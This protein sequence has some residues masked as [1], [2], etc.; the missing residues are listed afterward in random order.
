MKHPENLRRAGRLITALL[1]ALLWPVFWTGAATAQKGELKELE[2]ALQ[3]DEA[4][5]KA[6]AAELEALRREIKTLRSK[7]TTAARTAQDLEERLTRGEDRLKD[8]ETQRAAKLKVLE[9]QHSRLATTLAAL[10]RIARRPPEAVIV[11]PGSP[12][13]TY[14]SALLLSRAIPEIEGQA[15]ALRAELLALDGLRREIA[16]EQ[17]DLAEASQALSEERLS[18]SELIVQKRRLEDVT[19]AER[20]AARARVK[21]WAR[22]A[23]GLRE[24]LARLEN[25]AEAGRR[26]E[27][28]RIR[29][30]LAA[31]DARKQREAAKAAEAERQQQAQADQTEA[32]AEALTE[33]QAQTET[34]T[35]AEADESAESPAETQTAALA[36]PTASVPLDKPT[37]VRAFPGSPDE[38][39]LIMPARGR[40]TGLFGEIQKEGEEGLS[41]GI[42]IRTRAL[43]QIVAPYDGRIA[44]AGQFR[45]YGQ[46]LIIEHG[47]RYHTLLAGLTQVYAVEGQW[48]LA[49]EPVGT[50]GSDEE[51]AP[52]LY[53]ELRQG[54]HPIN[55]LPWLAT[56]E[57]KVQG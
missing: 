48:I 54:G 25:E 21:R 9:A 18:L 47:G 6:L 42:S 26:K 55:P 35:Q 39:S 4:R 40:L 8:L 46:I 22:E 14:R 33:T 49:G 52:V 12:S 31:A 28:E 15:D 11:A 50:M 32:Q 36:P 17:Q 1:L 2:Q 20:R 53:L 24:F 10:Q 30:A 57:N 43:A 41:Q 56:T 44:Y 37:N 51:T 45:R 3:E 5:A 27:A 34:E 16:R 13:D 23:N 7:M 38:A 29:Q 19:S